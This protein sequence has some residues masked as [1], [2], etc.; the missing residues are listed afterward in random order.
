MQDTWVKLF[1]CPRQHHKL[2]VLCPTKD[3][4]LLC[5]TSVC[6]NWCDACRC[7]F[8]P[9]GELFCFSWVNSPQ[10]DAFVYVCMCV[11][12]CV[13]VRGD[14]GAPI[15]TIRGESIMCIDQPSLSDRWLYCISQ[16]PHEV[17]AVFGQHWQ[18]SV[19]MS[20][21]PFLHVLFCHKRWN[22]RGRQ[23][24][25]VPE[26]VPWPILFR[27]AIQQSL[28]PERCAQE[29]WVHVSSFSARGWS[30]PCWQSFFTMM[31]QCWHSSVR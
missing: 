7:P 22:W 25:V 1:F 4:A 30:S 26:C 24:L 9:H 3:C 10:I 23:C 28:W 21:W 12:V 18:V 20:H 2:L 6:F 14:A 8:H 19:F 17:K 15:T 16:C 5:F 13:F 31:R 11:C 27:A 29:M